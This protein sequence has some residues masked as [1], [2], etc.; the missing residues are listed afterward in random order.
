MPEMKNYTAKDIERYHLGQMSPV[1]RHTL[2]KAALDDPFLA[3]ALEGY[4]YTST[5]EQDL[6]K[7]TARLEERKRDSK[8][9]PMF[10]RNNGWLKYA[11]MFL[12]IAG[13]GLIIY[14]TSKNKDS[15]LAS[16]NKPQELQQQNAPIPHADTSTAV[17][18]N[19]STSVTNETANTFSAPKTM[20]SKKIKSEPNSQSLNLTS[21]SPVIV[22]KDTNFRTELTDKSLD[23]TAAP[24]TMTIAADSGMAMNKGLSSKLKKDTVY[25]DDVVLKPL[26]NQQMNEVVVSGFGK[27]RKNVASMSRQQVIVDTL[28]PA[29]GWT[30]FND[31][32][33]NNLHA[34][35]ELK[36]KPVSS[37]D[38]E[39][40]FDVDKD[41][42]PIN[43]TVVKS[44]CAKCDEEAIRLLKD[45]PKWKKKK[46]K[47]G[48]VIIHF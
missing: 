38:V 21:S 36:V 11:A 3:D 6:E 19:G 28:E 4:V 20:D 16:Q 24:K 10:F 8:V 40:S 7:I 14:Q 5:P 12:I 29:V 23:V 13:G 1:E 26:P 46:N 48:K 39:L 34:P 25:L 22:Y 33:A 37:G 2:E 17:N 27:E 31:Y 45:G 32:V 9:I 30:N 43:I 35:E 15:N 41:G 42:V 47:K 18:N 44:L